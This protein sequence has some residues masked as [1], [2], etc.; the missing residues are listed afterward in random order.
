MH[1]TKEK[2]NKKIREL[3]AFRDVHKPKLEQQIKT[4]FEAVARSIDEMSKRD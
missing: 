3:E 2:N 1:S 4:L